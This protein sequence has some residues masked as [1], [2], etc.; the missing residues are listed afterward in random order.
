MNKRF[1]YIID[2]VSRKT[3][4]DFSYSE[5]SDSET[6][7]TLLLLDSSLT[8]GM[9][10]QVHIKFLNARVQIE[11]GFESVARKVLR[12]SL[13]EL[14][15]NQSLI[16]DFIKKH[17]FIRDLTLFSSGT[18]MDISEMVENGQ[19][20]VKDLNIVLFTGLVDLENEERVLLK[21]LDLV[22]PLIL[23]IFP[24]EEVIT[25]ELEGEKQELLQT[26]YERSRKNR[27]LCLTFYGYSCQGCGIN[28]EVEYGNLGKEFIHVHHKKPVS[29]SG[30]AVV[31]P[32]ED[33]IPLCPN[34]HSIVHRT[35]PPVEIERLKE[36]I[37][38][39]PY[40][41]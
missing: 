5:V 34:C 1:N 4:I 33:L 3:G 24:Y 19:D 37:K 18:K 23:L 28:M 32:V 38:N 27:A 9:G 13:T 10:Y 7:L 36:I 29:S 15:K 22:A 30:V 11:I 40:K 17:E 20:K 41:K 12:Y 14:E 31:D 16:K 21:V 2:S 8:L 26:K 35:N 39:G 25:G 6:K